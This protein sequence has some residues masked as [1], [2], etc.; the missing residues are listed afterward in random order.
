ML[1]ASSSLHDPNRNSAID[2]STTPSARASS[3]GGSSRLSVQGREEFRPFRVVPESEV[4]PKQKDAWRRQL[5]VAAATF[6][7]R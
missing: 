2:H 5:A 7:S 6:L 3:I 4:E 1:A